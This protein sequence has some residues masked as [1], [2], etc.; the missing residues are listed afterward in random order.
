[1]DCIIL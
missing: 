1:M